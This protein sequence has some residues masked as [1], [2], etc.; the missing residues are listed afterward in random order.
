VCQTLPEPRSITVSTVLLHDTSSWAG[1]LGPTG[2]TQLGV[3]EVS[4]LF[5][6]ASPFVGG[7]LA[8]CVHTP[9]EAHIQVRTPLNISVKYALRAGPLCMT[10]DTGPLLLYGDIS[11]TSRVLEDRIFIPADSATLISSHD[12]EVYLPLAPDKFHPGR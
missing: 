7:T 10:Q 5:K 9:K 4:H 11:D 12:T 3:F 1:L 6:H 2:V 8:W